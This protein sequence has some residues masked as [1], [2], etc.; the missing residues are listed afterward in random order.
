[1]LYQYLL[2]CRDVGTALSFN[3]RVGEGEC[4]GVLRL[5][6]EDTK[7]AQYKGE[8]KIRD[9]SPVD[10]LISLS[11]Q[12]SPYILKECGYIERKEEEQFWL[13]K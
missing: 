13:S 1:M 4:V 7:G 8:K 2:E 11:R 5:E 10:H 9:D 3:E 6:E 12:N